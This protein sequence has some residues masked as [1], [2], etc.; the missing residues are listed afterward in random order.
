MTQPSRY[1]ET[2]FVP[3]GGWPMFLLWGVLFVA[4]FPAAVYTEGLALIVFVP[5]LALLLCGFFVVSPNIARVLVLFGR[6]RGSVRKEGFYWTNP[7]TLRKRVSVK[8]H[9]LNGEKVKVNDLLGNPIE[10]AAVVVWQ[11]SD[12]A[13]ASFD[14]ENYEEFVRVQSEAAVRQLASAHPYDE[15]HTEVV[16][17]SLRGSADEIAVELQKALDQRLERAGIEVLEARISHLAYAPEIASAM[18]QRQQATAIIAARSMIVEGA[19][20]MVQMALDQLSRTEVVELDEE[21]KAQ[22]VGNLL[23]VLCAH[24]N[25][26]PVLN[27]G[28]LYA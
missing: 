3:L 24:D 1:T 11:V 27:T 15:G 28:S 13:R 14:V 7:F 12:S 6:Y 4:A 22:L 21:R 18:L 10:I 23:V 20:G 9:N 5:V 26:V 19:V 17:T 16:A 8:A 2:T 25:P